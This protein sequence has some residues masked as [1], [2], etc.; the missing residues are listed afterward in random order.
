MDRRVTPVNDRVAAAHLVGS[1]KDKN[2]VAGNDARICVPVADLLR[3]P[4][5]DRD[6]QL[7]LGAPISVF[8][9]RDG[10][11]FVQ[12]AQDDYV[13]YV[14][15]E[16]IEAA[17]AVTHRVSVRAT[18]MYPAADFKQRERDSLPMGALVEVTGI[19]G[20][21]AET[22]RGFVPLTHLL[23][24]EEREVDAVD[25]ADR[26]LGTP[27]LWGGNSCFGIDCS[28]L[29]QAGL[30]AVGQACPGDS[31]LQEAALGDTL[32]DGTTP[33]R[34]DLL[35]WK[36]HVAWV[37]D[38]DTLLHANAYHMAVAYEPLKQAIARIAEQGDGPVTRHA[39]LPYL[40]R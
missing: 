24:V 28:G 30:Y 18:H 5:G 10:W 39:R 22:E 35:F 19:D 14:R 3:D 40:R 6:R 34:G 15:L 4:G 1:V 27:Y 36:G 11:A 16:Q 2:F 12:A 7:L 26:L 9:E 20:R 21:F 31:D 23:P 8:E 33:E 32:P 37:A 13:G 25:V 17:R 38:K 29:V